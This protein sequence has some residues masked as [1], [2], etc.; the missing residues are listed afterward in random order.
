MRLTDH[1]EIKEV[2]QPIHANG[3]LLADLQLVP[4]ELYQPTSSLQLRK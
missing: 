3:K 4:P 1:P 2:G